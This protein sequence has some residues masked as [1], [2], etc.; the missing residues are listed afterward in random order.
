M[1]FRNAECKSCVIDSRRTQEI[2]VY[3]IDPVKNQYR[4]H[5]ISHIVTFSKR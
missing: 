1:L 5:D 4:I 2:A 3:E